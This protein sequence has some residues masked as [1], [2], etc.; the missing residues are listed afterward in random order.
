MARPSYTSAD[1]DIKRKD[2]PF[3]TEMSTFIDVVENNTSGQQDKI[4]SSYEDAVKTYEFT[5]QIR[6]ASEKFS[7]LFKGTSD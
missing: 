5:W 4:L 6:R 2:D 1:Q 7:K 3:Y